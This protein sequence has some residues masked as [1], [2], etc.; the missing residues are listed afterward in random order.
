MLVSCATPG[1]PIWLAGRMVCP[2]DCLLCPRI[3]LGRKTATP[4]DSTANKIFI[5][6][7]PKLLQL[8]VSLKPN[9]GSVRVEF[10]NSFDFLHW[11]P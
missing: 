2:P 6:V 11:H 1:V 7:L 3:N 5:L 10:A 8:L 9:I 4:L